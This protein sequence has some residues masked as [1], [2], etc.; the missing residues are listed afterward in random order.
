MRILASKPALRWLAPAVVVGAVA[1]TLVAASAQ[2]DK[3]LPPISAEQLLVDLQQS[4]I[5]GLSGTVIQEADLGIPAIPGAGGEDNSEL[6]S[7]ISG[8]HTL[9][10]R[11]AAPDKAR[12]AVFSNLGETDTITNGKDVWT[13]S[14]KG[15]KATH[16]TLGEHA[17]KANRSAPADAPQTPQEAAQ[18]FLSSITPSTTVSTDASVTVAGREAY[19]LVL[20]P[21]DDAAKVKQVRIAVDNVTRQPLR[22]QVFAANKQLV[23]GVGYK[24]VS[25]TRPDD[26]EFEFNA[27]PGTT[28]TEAPKVEHKAPSAKDRDAIEKKAAAAKEQ[29]KIVGTGWTSV[30][31]RKLDGAD[32]TAAN[33][34]LGAFLDRLPEVSGTWGKGRLLT[35]TA[36]SAVVTDDGR[37]A[38]GSVEPD[39]LYAALSK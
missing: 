23:L 21:N 10:I 37:I 12:L 29:T 8:T 24:Q 31:V 38:V 34:Q 30:V 28:V 25:F 33:G 16:R 14:S 3:S 2:A 19:E 17:D 22:V 5:D 6:T 26:A 35:G 7:L 9:R 4:K 18:K 20:D 32:P 36:F 11:Y 39:L 15:Q 27:P 1:T 13:W